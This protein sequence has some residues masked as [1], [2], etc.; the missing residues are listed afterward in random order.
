MKASTAKTKQCPKC[1]K[2]KPASAYAKNSTMGDGLQWQCRDCFAEY[3][4]KKKTTRA[5]VAKGSKRTLKRTPIRV[6][7]ELIRKCH[8]EVSEGLDY[9]V[10]LTD[11]QCVE[12]VLKAIL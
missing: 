11:Q 12:A 5:R 1:R 8:K 9:N 6:S 2:R 7:E 10:S 4:R 3:S